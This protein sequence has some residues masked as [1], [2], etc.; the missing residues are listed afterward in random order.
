MSRKPI[1][2]AAVV[3]ALGAG[4]VAPHAAD[5]AVPKKL[6]NEYLR[7]YKKVTKQG[8]KPGRNIVRDGVVVGKKGEKVRDARTAE[9]RRSLVVLYNMGGV[10]AGTARVRTAA[11]GAQSPRT[12]VTGRGGGG[13]PSCTWVPESGGDYGARGPGGAGGKYQIIPSTWKANGGSTANA[14]DASPAEQEAVAARVM[15]SQGPSAWVNC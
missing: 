15:A 6:R 8:G 13:L 14:A 5:A 9:V 2:G 7:A 3:A 10:S 1:V 12:A 4:A 11:P